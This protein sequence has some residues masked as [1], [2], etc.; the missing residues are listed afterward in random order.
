MDKEKAAMLENIKNYLSDNLHDILPYVYKIIISLIIL[1]IASLLTRILL[2][3]LEKGVKNLKDADDTSLPIIEVILKYSLYGIALLFIL[4]LFGVN[5]NS[6]IALVGVGGVAIGFAL[7]NTLSNVAS[8][9]ML[10]FQRPFKNGDS[11]ATGSSSGTVEEIGLFTTRLRT[12][13]GVY[14]CIPNNSLWSTTIINYSRNHSRRIEI[15]LTMSYFDSL[16]DAIAMLNKIIKEENRILTEKTPQIMVK[17]LDSTTATLEL[18]VWTK[19]S[20]YWD[21]FWSLNR[22]IKLAIEQSKLNITVMRNEIY[23]HELKD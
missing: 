16:D 20:E 12:S 19:T 4:N 21:V 3:S 15:P 10:L 22:N 23:V 7:K 8:G 1:Y 13:S 5:T 18:R 2:R 11:I 6:I 14:L 17:S 9:F